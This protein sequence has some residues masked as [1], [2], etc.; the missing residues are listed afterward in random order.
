MESESAREPSM[1]ITQ[2]ILDDL[3][4]KAKENPRLRMAMDLRNSPKDL[5]QRMLGWDGTGD[6]Y[7]SQV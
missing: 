7:L 4:A 2:Q 6:R 3:T 5:S 1:I